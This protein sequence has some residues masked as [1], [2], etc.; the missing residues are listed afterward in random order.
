MFFEIIKMNTDTKKMNS[1]FTL[2]EVLV[3]LSLFTIVVTMAV[4]TLLVL[5]DAN[6]KQ[7]NMQTVMT[8]LSFALDSMTREIRTGYYYECES[9]SNNLEETDGMVFRNC[10]SGQSNFAFSE[11][12]GSL[13]A[14]KGSSRIGYRL[15][16][17]SIER[18]LGNSATTG[19]DW[20]AIT[21]PEVI[22]TELDFVVT[23]ADPLPNTK[24]PTVT[25]FVSG[26]VGAASDIDAS[27]DIQTTITQQI[28]DI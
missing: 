21:A 11:S 5:I 13:T 8:N 18:R 1:G 9:N 26:T 23:D 2:V 12:G 19:F 20:H 15:N 28:L 25:I 6:G 27:F 16:G 24:S 22:V 4:G 14:D 3:S 17:T 7:Q 10:S